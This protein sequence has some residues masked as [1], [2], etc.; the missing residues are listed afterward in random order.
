MEGDPGS[1]FLRVELAKLYFQMGRVADAVRDAEEVLKINPDQEEAHRLLA[2]VYWRNLGQSQPDQ[3]TKESLIKAILH[4]EAL[5]RLNPKDIDNDMKLGRLYRLNN[6]GDKAEEVF[7]K[8]L[9][10]SPDSKAA[11]DGLAQLYF[12]HGD[13]DQVVELLKSIPVEDLDSRQLGMLAYSLQ[14][15]R[16]FEEAISLYEKSLAESPNNQDIR[17][18]YAN[19]LT[20]AGRNA[21]ARTELQKIIRLQPE[22]GLTPPAARAT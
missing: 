19:A 5:S 21:A 4:F 15:A 13:F 16:D 8:I 1:L 3:V 10:S 12:D 9:E 17:R 6:Q 14:Q 18:A 11:L 2:H 7:K 22:D 20:S